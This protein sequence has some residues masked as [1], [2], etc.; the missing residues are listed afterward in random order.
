VLR[1]ST[2]EKQQTDL[3]ETNLPMNNAA[4]RFVL[5]FSV[6][7][8]FAGA[9]ADDKI[10]LNERFEVTGASGAAYYALP[11]PVEDG[12]FTLTVHY[13]SG[14]PRMKGGFVDKEFTIEDGYFEYYYIN[15]KAE[16]SGFFKEGRKVGPWERYNWDGSRKPDRIY[17][18]EYK[19]HVEERNRI[20]P[21]AFPGDD[22]ALFDFL[23]KSIDPKNCTAGNGKNQ[24]VHIGFTVK[25]TGEITGAYV[26]KSANAALDAEALRV[27]EQMPLWQ[28]ALRN[29]FPVESTFILPVAFAINL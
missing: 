13:L 2:L 21:A 8:C 18:G 26:A 16:S 6:W 25:T 24:V 28:P 9:T 10:Y 20:Q 1:H 22:E 11:G 29:G 3:T 23:A 19:R 5:L 4:V 14:A 12:L 27:V 7:V 15:G 17:A